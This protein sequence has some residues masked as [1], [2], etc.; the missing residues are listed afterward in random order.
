MHAYHVVTWGTGANDILVD[1]IALAHQDMHVYFGNH[2]Y[3]HAQH[4]L[5][6][7]LRFWAGVALLTRAAR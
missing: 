7:A 2:L 5:G 3:S 4:A 1:S 6:L